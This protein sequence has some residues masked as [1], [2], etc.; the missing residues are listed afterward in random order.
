LLDE[1][2]ILKS[3]AQKLNDNN[4]PYML[5][6]SVAMSYYS[7]PRMTRDIDIVIEINDIENFYRLFKD[8]YYIDLDTVRDSV[9]NRGI[10]NI[11]HSVEIIKI[12]FIVRKDSA[13]RK[14]EFERRKKIKFNDGYIY[15]VSIEDLIISK[16]IWYKESE[17][18]MQLKDIKNLLKENP[19][20]KYLKEWCIKLDL[21]ELLEEA[22][23]D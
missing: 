16:L 7:A 23:V 17:S 12:D 21:T 10:F 13:Y 4:I 11:I 1:F 14:K 22:L 15:L 6:G 20:L 2:K 3:I 5:T 18:E 19:D 9:L 8:D